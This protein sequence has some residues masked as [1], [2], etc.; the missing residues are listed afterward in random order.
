[1]ENNGTTR[2]A[3][4]VKLGTITKT[5]KWF[6]FS[7]VHQLRMD[8]FVKRR[9]RKQEK[10]SIALFSSYYLTIWGDFVEGGG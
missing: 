9:H 10:Y 1:M 6:A 2:A 8:L 3:A 7:V 5:V 4:I